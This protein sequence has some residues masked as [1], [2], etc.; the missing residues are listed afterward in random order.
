MADFKGIKPGEMA[1]MVASE[2]TGKSLA[3]RWQKAYYQYLKLNE[4]EISE[5]ELEDRFCSM[6]KSLMVMYNENPERWSGNIATLLVVYSDQYERLSEN[7]IYRGAKPNPE[8]T[9][10]LD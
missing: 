2:N 10:W 3:H 5:D 8:K 4:P 1:V 6:T 7:L 9:R